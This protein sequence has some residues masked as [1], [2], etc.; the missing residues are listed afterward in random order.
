VNEAT[1]R[2]CSFSSCIRLRC[3]SAAALSMSIDCHIG[4]GEKK[5][6]GGRKADHGNATSSKKSPTLL[7]RIIQVASCLFSSPTGSRERPL[8]N[9]TAN[10]PLGRCH[11]R[12][13]RLT[14][15]R[16]CSSSGFSCCHASFIPP[17]ASHWATLHWHAMPSYNLDVATFRIV[18]LQSQHVMISTVTISIHACNALAE[19]DSDSEP[20]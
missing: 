19:A 10:D 16:S 9:L 5:K 3:G 4:R 17:S 15:M 8:T 1:Q 7:A 14:L 11:L 6:Q 18:A 2:Q 13:S 20:D 12:S